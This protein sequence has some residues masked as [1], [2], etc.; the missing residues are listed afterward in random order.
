MI[1]GKQVIF[2][3]NILWKSWSKLNSE[4]LSHS[5]SLANIDILVIIK[6][7]GLDNTKRDLLKGG[8]IGKWIFFPLHD[9]TAWKHAKIRVLWL[10]IL[11]GWTDRWMD[12]PTDG[13]TD[14]RTYGRMDLRTDRLSYKYASKNGIWIKKSH[15]VL[16]ACMQAWFR[17]FDL[18]KRISS[19]LR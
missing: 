14:G 3:Q 6:M 18:W 11:D 1:L 17:D 10:G 16:H 4:Q 7:T 12:G 15:D 19:W 13:P 5:M 2:I 9:S 8:H